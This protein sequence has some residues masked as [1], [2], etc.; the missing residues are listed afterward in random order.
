M[1]FRYLQQLD[2]RHNGWK[3]T[4]FSLF[5]HGIEIITR[6]VVGEGE[7]LATMFKGLQSAFQVKFYGLR[8]KIYMTP[9]VCLYRMPS[10]CNVR[11]HMLHVWAG[12]MWYNADNLYYANWEIYQNF[13][14][15]DGVCILFLLRSV[16]WHSSH[17][18]AI[19]S[20]YCVHIWLDTNYNN[21]VMGS[22]IIEGAN[23][24]RSICRIAQTG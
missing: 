8:M 16:H 11:I 10:N 3:S 23:F 4:R 7:G 12:P 18:C 13:L 9:N 14:W 1:D 24:F 2:R 6:I 17:T 19:H 15:A 20:I 22:S 21:S 5:Y